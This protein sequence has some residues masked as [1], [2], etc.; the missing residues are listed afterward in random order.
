ML[1]PLH[2]CDAGMAFSMDSGLCRNDSESE[3]RLVPDT[4]KFPTTAK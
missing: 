4:P 2:T 3:I 1:C